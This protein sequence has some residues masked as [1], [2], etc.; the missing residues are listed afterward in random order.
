MN[1]EIYGDISDLLL[2]KYI[3][4]NTGDRFDN[5]IWFYDKQ[6]KCRKTYKRNIWKNSLSTP[7][8]QTIKTSMALV[9]WKF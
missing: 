1:T 8:C 5:I 2:A 3:N 6:K 7:T 4:F 9:P